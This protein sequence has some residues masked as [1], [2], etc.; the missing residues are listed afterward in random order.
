MNRVSPA[1]DS[2]SISPPCLSATMAWL[3]GRPRPFPE[4]TP[5][6]VKILRGYAGAV[7]YDL[8]DHLIVVASGLN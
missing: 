5:F 8:H 4:P 6:V 7:V 3:I 2:I 1:F